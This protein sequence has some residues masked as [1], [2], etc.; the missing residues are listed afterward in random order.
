MTTPVFPNQ[1][2]NEKVLLKLRRHWLTWAWNII[3]LLLFNLIPPGLYI[4]FYQLIGWP[5]PTEGL[6][7][8]GLVLLLSLYYLGAWLIFYHAFVDYHLDVWVLTDQRIVNVE[9]Q[10]LFDRTISELNILK[11]QDVTS[12]IHGHLQTFFNFGNVY[13]QT[14]GEQQRFIFQNVPHPE[15]VARI[16]IHANDIALQKNGHP[17]NLA[18]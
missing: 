12:E 10:G 9:Q 14:A 8:I 16:I 15:D 11:V 4:L 1:R 2:P 13:I 6:L 3:Q 5:V 7:Y 17:E 18:A